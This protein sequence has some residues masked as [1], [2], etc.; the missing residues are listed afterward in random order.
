MPTLNED[1]AIQILG[2][3]ARWS[4]DDNCYLFPAG[5]S[6]V[7]VEDVLATEF[8]RENLRFV[9]KS[10]WWAEDF[11]NNL[12]PCYKWLVSGNSASDEISLY[13]K[14]GA[15]RWNE[16]VKV[17]EGIEAEEGIIKTNVEFTPPPVD[18]VKQTMGRS[19]TEGLSFKACDVFL[20]NGT[21]LKGFRRP[22][23]GMRKTITAT[24]IS[25]TIEF[26]NVNGAPD[27]SKTLSGAASSATG[28]SINGWDF[29]KVKLPGDMYIRASILRNRGLAR[30]GKP[31][32]HRK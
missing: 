2:K 8:Q 10:I 22:K 14:T 21:M 32:K 4:G 19:K 30:L 1:V 24:I 23:G 11:A 5:I 12:G 17:E 13:P 27:T 20:P 29:W 3:Y 26:Q 6:P 25:G 9:R 31:T 28:G 15:V 16:S 7:E 18:S